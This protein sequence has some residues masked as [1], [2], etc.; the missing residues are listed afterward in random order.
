MKIHGSFL[1][2]ILITFF[3]LF[4][5][6]FVIVV[7]TPS[8]DVIYDTESFLKTQTLNILLLHFVSSFSLIGLFSNCYSSRR[9]QI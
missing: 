2:V 7:C 6:F 8:Y 3:F 4:Q 5:L 1:N 9:E